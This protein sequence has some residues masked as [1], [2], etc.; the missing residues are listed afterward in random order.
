MTTKTKQ[1]RV[2]R[3]LAEFDGDPI[4]APPT[5]NEPGLIDASLLSG[6]ARLGRRGFLGYTGATAAAVGFA[7]C[8][9]RP[10]EN[11][12]PYSQAPEYLVPGVALHFA[13]TMPRRGDT[14]GMLVTS[15]EGRP[16]KIEGNPQHSG[17]RGGMDIAGQ[18]AVWDLYD[19]DRSRQAVG[20]G[21]EAG[22]D[23][24]ASI[25][26]FD[27]AMD[28]LIGGLGTGQGLRILAPPTT[29]PS[30]QRLRSA[31]VRR[32]PRATFHTYASIHEANLREGARLA[33]GQP[34]A[35]VID[36]SQARVVLSLD[37]DFLGTEPGAIRSARG[38]AA[39]R[40]ATEPTAA[41][42][43]LYVVEAT[44]SVTGGAADHR[45]R[46]ASRDVERFL[47][48][49]AKTLQSMEG[50]ELGTLAA[51]FADAEVPAEWQGWMDP[52][53][54]DL[55]S[56]LGRAPIV[57]GSRQPPRV[58]A[59]AHAINR[60]LRNEGTS[61]RF[62]APTDPNPSD[63]VADIASL[64]EA[65]G[66][67]SV[68]TLLMLGGNPV[69]DSPADV[70][71]L[72]ALGHEGLTSIHLASHRDET[73]KASTWHFPLAHA[74]ETWGD[75]RALDGSISIQQPL[76]APLFGGRSEVELL[77]RFAGERNWR[78]HYV[79]RK[80]LRR[81]NGNAVSFERDWR[82]ALHSGV[83][84]GSG[85]SAVAGLPLNGEN[86]L[87]ALREGGSVERAALGANNLEVVFVPD[88][89]M[90]DG[91]HAN[92]MWALELPDPL[93][94][95]VWDNAALMSRTTRDELGL[96]TG[97]V[98]RLTKGE[99]SIELPVY[100]LPGHADFSLT[101]PLGWGRDATDLRYARQGDN[102][103][104]AGFDVQP[105]R[106]SDG[107]HFTDGVTLQSTGRVYDMVQ[108]QTHPHMEGRPIVIEG[109]TTEWAE[110]PEF[111]QYDAVEFSNGPLWETVDYSAG[112]QWGMSIDLS[113]CTGCNACVIACQAENNL[114][115][116]G[117]AE[118]KRGREMH[119][120]RIDRY[121]VGDDANPQ[122]ALQPLGCM[123][124]EEAP[125]ENVC[126]INATSHTPEGL[127]DMAYNRCVGTRYCANNCP[128][129]VRRFNYLDWHGHLDGEPELVGGVSGWTPMYGDFPETR[130]M[131]FNPNVTVRMRGVME[132]CTY[133]VQRI[134][135]AKITARREH[136]DLRDGDI[137]VAC[138]Q[139]CPSQSIVFG[140]LNDSGSRV[141]RLAT[142]SRRYKLLAEI[143]TRPRTTYLAKI[144]NPNPRLADDGAEEAQG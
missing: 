131:Q 142:V 81:N 32:F 38:F 9:R 14:V 6:K 26:T 108:T 135:Q 75:H 105:L 113:S 106:T 19:P 130:Q 66:E 8:V 23:A 102:G 70:D 16:T 29:S 21:A 58:H 37:S 87:R 5:E 110:N 88:P 100:V 127:N 3:S 59:L 53:A 18:L 72:G 119:W 63:H 122:V 54:T 84:P 20:P 114:P 13:T 77:A 69:Y 104:R 60:R 82:R 85:A 144:R 78:G 25:A 76:I 123:Q 15:H 103:D 94:K 89:R 67:G 115:T 99:H 80:T 42:N 43:R 62:H 55:L 132:K 52:L 1:K 30:F 61:V 86:L 136:R 112:H 138:E 125:C 137:V 118:V 74:L 17:S 116:V 33:F 107:F 44:H 51:A 41:A 111:P 2:W 83:V 140:D 39:G 101:L 126:P 91:R 71:F 141:A 47:L 93:T 49:L 129:K 45:I 92:N 133:C 34:L 98:V 139:T 97:E 27:S 65:I 28:A 143:G 50:F 46:V 121:F 24:M 128:Y 96:A 7:G 79:V 134:Q 73:G 64:V 40:S 12:L 56:N 124:C 31:V 95:L 10:V 35:Q 109:T 48:A 4:A 36:Y 22:S 120:L 90:F 11:I 117:K 68:D 57:V